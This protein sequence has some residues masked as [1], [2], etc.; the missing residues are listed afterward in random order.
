M[1]GTGRP[2]AQR[3]HAEDVTGSSTSLVSVTTARFLG[4]IRILRQ[5]IP[6]YFYMTI[7]V[8][9][10][11]SAMDASPYA[12]AASIIHATRFS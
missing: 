3:W 10:V 2:P 12:V 6:F 11:D 8:R 5:Y 1:V 7:H 4:R 9:G